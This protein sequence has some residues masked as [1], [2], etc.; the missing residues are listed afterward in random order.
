[1]TWAKLLADN[2][3]SKE[4]PSKLETDNLRSI[5]TRSLKDVTASGLSADAR[6]V[7]LMDRFMPKWHFYRAVLNRLPVRHENWSY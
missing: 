6:F 1:M 7:E 5:V 3:V 4:P 2:R